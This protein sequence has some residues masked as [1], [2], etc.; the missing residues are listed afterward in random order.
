MEDSSLEDDLNCGGLDQKV[1]EKKNFSMLSRYHSYDI[2]VKKVAA[3]C[4]GPKC[5]PETK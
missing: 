5:L 4:S 1:S 2:L 3:F